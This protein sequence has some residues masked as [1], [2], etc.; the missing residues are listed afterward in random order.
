MHPA[1]LA[2]V[3]AVLTASRVL[4][5]VAARSIADAGHDIT[6]PQYRVLIVLASKGPARPGD[7]A[8]ALAISSSTTTRLCDRL[9]R[10]GLISREREAEAADRRAVSLGLTARGRALVDE[11]TARRRTEIARIVDMVP[12]HD[13]SRLVKAFAA[14]ASAA[15]EVPDAEWP[16]RWEL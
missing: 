2:V 6:I 11:V 12:Q 3:E 1:P 8:E 5:A 13:R 16:E 10:K 7:L 15:G 14:F 9:A 4:V